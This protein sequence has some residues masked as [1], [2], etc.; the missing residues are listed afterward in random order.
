MFA[1]NAN[2]SVIRAA[3]LPR[4]QEPY[5]TI[6]V[7]HSCIIALVLIATTFGC[8]GCP[9]LHAC[10]TKHTNAEA[11]LSAWFGLVLAEKA[12]DKVRCG[13]ILCT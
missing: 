5:I 2:K 3:S 4:M 9:P 6:Q 10:G 11:L 12:S 13:G 7:T 8:N 1:T